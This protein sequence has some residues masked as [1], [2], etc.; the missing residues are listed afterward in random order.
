MFCLACFMG[1]MFFV[2]FLSQRAYV[3]ATVMA[4]IS[5]LI[6]LIIFEID[7]EIRSNDEFAIIGAGIME[8][9]C[10]VSVFL[11][12]LICVVVRWVKKTIIQKRNE[13]N[14]DLARH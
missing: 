10:L 9:F 11:C 8:V 1:L 6:A 5:A 12:A 14:K 7:S 4:I 2:R 3:S 13:R